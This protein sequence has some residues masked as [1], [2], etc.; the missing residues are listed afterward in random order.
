MHEKNPNA[1][2][3]AALR[4][5]VRASIEGSAVGD[6]CYAL[7]EILAMLMVESVDRAKGNR[8]DALDAL[9][10]IVRHAQDLVV[11]NTSEPVPIDPDAGAE[12]F[13]RA[14]D[15]L[16]VKVQASFMGEAADV[17]H[18]VLGNLWVTTLLQV[19]ESADDSSEIFHAFSEDV[20]ATV[21]NHFFGDANNSSSSLLP[22]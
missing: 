8:V 20:L 5:K 1:A 10:S 17:V 7:V 13:A 11:I 9:F 18:V 19:A 22:N 4:A 3:P 6:A 2:N 21:Q 14:C 15:A 16:T 12:H